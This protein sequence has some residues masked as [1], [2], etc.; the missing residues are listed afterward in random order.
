MDG[1]NELLSMGWWVALAISIIVLL[2]C[3]QQ[4]RKVGVAILKSAGAFCIV[5]VLWQ[6]I[7]GAILVAILIAVILIG[8]AAVAGMAD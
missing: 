7:I 1:M 3:L 4:E 5:G 2:Y 6:L 8:V